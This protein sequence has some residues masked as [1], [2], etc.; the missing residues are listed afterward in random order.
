MIHPYEQDLGAL[1]VTRAPAHL[2]DDVAALAL[3]A[4]CPDISAARITYGLAWRRTRTA[5]CR[6]DTS[7][8]TSG[9]QARSRSS[10][11]ASPST[12]KEAAGI[13]SYK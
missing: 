10:S 4:H 11:P 3:I 2:D 1:Y 7:Y 6:A 9:S 13:R 5:A 12:C 8:L